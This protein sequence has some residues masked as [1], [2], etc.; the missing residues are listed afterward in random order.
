MTSQGTKSLLSLRERSLKALYKIS[1]NSYVIF[2][3][4]IAESSGLTEV[5]H[6]TWL[7]IHTAVSLN[8]IVAF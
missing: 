4:N 5:T 8:P 7:P 3:I 2:D 6:F 1:I